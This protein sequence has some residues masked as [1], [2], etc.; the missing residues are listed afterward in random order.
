[1]NIVAHKSMG[2]AAKKSVKVV[3]LCRFLQQEASNFMVVLCIYFAMQMISVMQILTF[4]VFWS[5]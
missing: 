2:N 3:Q 4:L 1:M 5:N